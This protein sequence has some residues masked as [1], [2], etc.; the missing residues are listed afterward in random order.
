MV[1]M[2]P[3]AMMMDNMDQESVEMFGQGMVPETSLED[4]TENEKMMVDVELAP[5][6]N[7]E[8]VGHNVQQKDV[9]GVIERLIF[10][11]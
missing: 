11:I 2:E 8:D 10:L 3:Q 5:V 7:N 1:H 4:E 9:Q 6:G